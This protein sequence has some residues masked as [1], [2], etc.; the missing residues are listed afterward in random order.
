MSSI[1]TIEP[2]FKFTVTPKVRMGFLFCIT[3]VATILCIIGQGNF[4]EFFMNFIFFMSYF[5]IPW[6]SINLVDYYILLQGE[7][8][9]KDI[10]DLNGKYGKSTELR[11]LHS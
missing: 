8:S 6:T 1:T 5:L 11:S 9:V 4:L 2:F 3:A 10:F 7:Y